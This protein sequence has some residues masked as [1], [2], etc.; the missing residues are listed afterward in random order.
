MSHVSRSDLALRDREVERPLAGRPCA[1][2][3]IGDL[4][5]KTGVE[6]VKDGADDA[7]EGLGHE[8]GD[9]SAEWREQIP[10]RMQHMVG[11]TL[12]AE[13]AEIVRHARD[14]V[15]VRTRVKEDADAGPQHAA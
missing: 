7:S 12:A 14:G 5:C 15:A 1:T 6:A 13:A 10:V 9:A 2:K 8:E 4:I 3:G 11:Q